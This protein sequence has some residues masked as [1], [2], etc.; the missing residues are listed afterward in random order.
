[1]MAAEQMVKGQS[2]IKLLG[3]LADVASSDDCLISGLQLDSRKITQNDLF[4]AC[5]GDQVHGLRFSKQA[6]EQGA[7]AI[8]YDPA[9]GEQSLAEELAVESLLIPI[10]ELTE[11]IGLI[12]SRFYGEPS[13][14]LRLV[15]VTGTNGKT[16]CTH[17]LAQSLKG[18]MSCATVGTLGWGIDADWHETTHTTP[19]AVE[20]NRIMAELHAK[21]ARVVAL[22][23]SSHGLV[24][25]RTA[26]SH[27]EGAVFTNFS[28]DHLDYH[29]S[30]N[31]YIEAKLLLL[32]SEGLSFVVVNLD[33]SNAGKV[34][35]AVPDS[36]TVWGFTS[37]P[38]L[39]RE[40]QCQH[41][42]SASD[43][44]ANREGLKFK[45]TYQ[46]QS[47]ALTVPL[48]GLF[49]LENS[50][51]VLTAL[52]AMGFPLK[53]ATFMVQK[54]TPIAGRMELISEVG[55]P[56]VVVDYA[57]TPDALDKALASLRPHCK[58]ELKVLFGCGGDRDHGKRP[59]MGEVA[60]KQA[61]VVYLTDDNPRSEDGS[62]IIA[63]IVAGSTSNLIIERDRKR[64]IARVIADSSADDVILVAGKGHETTQQVGDLLLPFDDR[65]IVRSCLKMGKL[66]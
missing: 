40:D 8:I 25:G 20:L 51:A 63:E 57:H 24:Q 46:C 10:K 12:A 32:K 50:L 26:G 18:E 58:G 29:G 7:A 42:V 64:A 66:S 35:D 17:F 52:L 37:Q 27:F 36:V 44:A 2:L 13:K 53:K 16:S 6:I 39:E 5:A 33:D 41:L 47:E 23:V 62:A 48:I 56:L 54:I 4:L 49:N 59:L 22:E 3:E 19:D 38:K 55:E 31:D 45:V 61:D 11:K 28:R 9:E 65:E 14:S 30:F 34:L 1:M 43:V 21:E 60:E 15:G